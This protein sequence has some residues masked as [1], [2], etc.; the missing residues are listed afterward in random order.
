MATGRA[1][2]RRVDRA[3]VAPGR[4]RSPRAHLHGRGSRGALAVGARRATSA[5]ARWRTTAGSRRPC[6]TGARHT[7]AVGRRRCGDA[8]GRR[9]VVMLARGIAAPAVSSSAP[10]RR[11]GSPSRRPRAALSATA[12]RTSASPYRRTDRSWPTSRPTRR[13]CVASGFARFRRSRRVRCQAPTDRASVFWSPDGRSL[14]FFAGDKLKRIELPDGSPVTISDVPNVRL[15]ATWGR[16]ADS[17]FVVPRRDLSRSG[18]RRHRRRSSTPHRPGTR[19][20]CAPPGPRSCRTAGGISTSPRTRRRRRHHDA[21]RTRKGAARQSCR[22]CSTAQ[23]VDPGYL[24]VC[25]RRHARR[26]A[27]R[28]V[29]SAG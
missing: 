28:R 11:S 3:H 13:A 20:D 16:R 4:A 5:A 25:P 9:R 29:A 8:D 7:A 27:L 10:R 21:R 19:R 14:A 2:V 24:R 18:Q 17:V 15:S 6:R 26:P 23:Y 22:R 12:S 1:R